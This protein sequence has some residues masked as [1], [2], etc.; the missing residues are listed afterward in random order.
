MT[1]NPH[2]I[3]VDFGIAL[4]PIPITLSVIELDIVAILTFVSNDFIIVV[5]VL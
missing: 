1:D 4:N 3:A 2:A 5:N